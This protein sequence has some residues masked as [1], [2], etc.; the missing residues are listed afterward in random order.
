MSRPSATVKWLFEVTKL[1][2]STSSRMRTMVFT[3][4]GTSMPTAALPGIGASMRTPVA[5]RFIARS[6]ARFVILLIFTPAANIENFGLHTEAFQCF[7]KQLAVC[8]ELFGLHGGIYFFAGSEH[9][10]RWE[11]I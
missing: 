10:N 11:D 5:A 1:F 3:L 7:H 6:S 4:F 2:D 9:R 8:L